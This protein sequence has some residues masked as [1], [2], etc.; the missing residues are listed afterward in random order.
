MKKIF[1]AISVILPIICQAQPENLPLYFKTAQPEKEEELTQIPELFH[2]VYVS[3]KD[4]L[5]ALH[6]DADSVYTNISNL[7]IITL[8]QAKELNLEVKGKFIHGLGKDPIEVIQKS[9]TVFFWM[10]QS[11]TFFRFDSTHTAKMADDFLMININNKIGQWELILFE[12]NYEDNTLNLRYIETEKEK[13]KIKKIKNCKK[14][15]IDEIK[16]LQAS[17]GLKEWIPYIE[18]EGFSQKEIFSQREK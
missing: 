5:K 2:G 11:Y 17:Q 14:I 10:I 18:N 16:F 13:E 1:L 7:F 4:S 6:I 3:K 15:T 8:K 9:D 12:R